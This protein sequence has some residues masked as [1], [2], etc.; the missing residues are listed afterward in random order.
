MLSD[1]YLYNLRQ[2]YINVGLSL[3][4]SPQFDGPIDELEYDI[5]YGIMEEEDITNHLNDMEVKSKITHHNKSF[6]L[7]KMNN[8]FKIKAYLTKHN[9][10]WLI[11]HCQSFYSKRV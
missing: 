6:V 9:N 8:D 3:E 2:K 11:E 5:I 1:I 7:F 4:Q 10:I